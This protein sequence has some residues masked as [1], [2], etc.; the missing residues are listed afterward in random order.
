M[1]ETAD[2]TTPKRKPKTIEFTI[3]GEEYKFI[4]PKTAGIMFE[5]IEAKGDEGVAAT[6]AQFDWLGQGLDEYDKL[7]TYADNPEL[8]E[9]DEPIPV[10]DLP[11]DWRGPQHARIIERLKDP[12][13]DLDLDA[14]TR[15]LT[16]IQKQVAGR[17][18]G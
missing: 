18:T 2:F 5:I 16:W 17:P 9:S 7:H 10:E 13:D 15:Y 12:K 3:D 1:A 6:R 8:D 14:I 4:A 11:K